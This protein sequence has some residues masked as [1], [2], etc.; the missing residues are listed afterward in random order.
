MKPLLTLIAILLMF[1]C[2]KEQKPEEKEKFAFT[3]QITDCYTN[4][5]LKNARVDII[6]RH[7]NN[8][9]FFMWTKDEGSTYTDENGYYNIRPVKYIGFTDIQ[10]GAII[11]PADMHKHFA[12][13]QLMNSRVKL[14]ETILCK[15]FVQ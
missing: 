7:L 4:T 9:G 8:G 6:L 5:P 13:T 14:T 12:A 2:R 11:Q 15:L 1:S 10:I 3:G